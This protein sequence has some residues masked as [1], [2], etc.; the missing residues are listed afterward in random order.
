MRR[1]ETGYCDVLVIGMGMA[2][3]ASALFA[4]NRGLKVVQAGLAGEIPFSSGLM[5]LL[6][7]HPVE[8]SRTWED[9]WAGMESLRKDIPNHPY[10]LLSRTEIE[11]ALA[12][13]F[14]FLDE[15]GL[16]YIKEHE[17]N[18]EM[19]MPTGMIKQTYAVPSS[20]WNG[21]RALKAKTPCLLVDFHGITEFSARQMAEVMQETWPGLRSARIPF[22]GKNNQGV[23]VTGEILAADMESRRNRKELLNAVRPL[24]QDARFLG[25]PAVFGMRRTAEILAELE[26]EIGIPIF[27]IPT[28]P[29]SIPGLRLNDAFARGLSRKGVRRLTQSRVLCLQQEE[30]RGFLLRIGRDGRECVARA[31][32]VILATGRF[33]G[34][35]LVADRDRIREP[36]LDLPVHQPD[37]REHWHRN[38]FLD[39]RG[40]P[41]NRAGLEIDGLFRPLDRTGGPAFDRL[42]AAGS[43]LAHQDWMRMKCGSGLAIGSAYGAVKGFLRTA[44]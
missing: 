9:P 3:M 18:V 43:I 5:D 36:L 6:G 37:G 23:L 13:V 11:S 25:F 28:F 44:K 17:Q 4:A 40:H 16:L 20:M 21:V 22:P 35:G 14:S 33:W 2:G 19:I 30:E 42:F 7:V 12:D 26:Q 1:S 38:D 41:V 8:N 31:E 34:R 24:I 29:V 10:G 15:Q 32:G 27:E 39:L